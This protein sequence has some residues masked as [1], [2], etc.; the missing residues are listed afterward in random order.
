MQIQNPE[1][2]VSA[3]RE[4]SPSANDHF[5]LASLNPEC[6][7]FRLARDK[8]VSV[9]PVVDALVEILKS[10]PVLVALDNTQI[11]TS[12]TSGCSW[13]L[14]H[15]AQWLLAQARRRDPVH[16][17]Q[18]LSEFL[19][20][21]SLQAL[22]VMPLW[23][24]NP[25]RQIPLY[26]DI[27]LVPLSDVPATIP[28]DMLCSVPSSRLPDSNNF[29]RVSRPLAALVR[30][31]K[32]EPVFN[33]AF[34]GD[35]QWAERFRSAHQYR[36]AEMNEI[37]RVLTLV[38][39][40]P[41]F[42][43]AHWFQIPEDTP[44][45]GSVGGWSGGHFR[46][47]FLRLIKV[48]DYADTEMADLVE[49]YMNRDIRLRERLDVPLERLRTAMLQESLESTAI[50]LGIALESLLTHEQDSEAPIS[51]RLR[52]RATHLLGGTRDNRIENAKRFRVLYV[53]RSRAAHGAKVTDSAL[54]D[55][56]G[57]GTAA[58]FLSDCAK[59]TSL[60]I[61]RLIDRGALPDWE[62]LA[63]GWEEL[64]P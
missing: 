58:A 10:E 16:V 18:D 6:T 15:V 28:K 62:G 8:A 19:A 23:G 57:S 64:L 1:R 53:L 12:P 59:L 17:V 13:D 42:P 14:S 56:A 24:L 3:L 45:L 55:A 54:R 38:R 31:F 34:D 63:M 40:S 9:G 21:S 52:L 2:L 25:S 51:Y 4:L 26:N 11:R 35:L 61:R 39:D 48:D 5:S 30:P 41:V 7:Q 60:M 22:E 20:T 43:I 37:A 33:P 29:A 44:V 36:K 27:R 47:A 49:V 50:D 32:H 46:P